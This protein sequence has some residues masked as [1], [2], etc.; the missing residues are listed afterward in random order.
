MLPILVA[1]ACVDTLAVPEL[2]LG[3]TDLSEDVTDFIAVTV[4]G[5]LEIF[6]VL[7]KSAV[8]SFAGID[9]GTT[10]L[11]TLTSS[12]GLSLPLLDLFVRMFDDNPL[13][14]GIIFG[15]IGDIFFD[16]A[17]CVV[18]AVVVVEAVVDISL[19]FDF[20]GFPEHVKLL[21]ITGAADFA[22]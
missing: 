3:F 11:V 21:L 1:G 13:V 18:R 15:V 10:E 16:P 22:K 14:D 5:E 17:D 12:L 20:N 19:L 8:D 7:L 4:S 6:L 2:E 9:A